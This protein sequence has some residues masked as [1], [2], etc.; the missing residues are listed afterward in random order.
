MACV[1]RT[2]LCRDDNIGALVHD[3]DTGATA[4]IDV[5]HAGP[6]LEALDAEGWSLSDILITHGHFD[7]VAGIPELVAKTGATVTAPALSAAAIGGV[8]RPVSEGDVIEVGALR[9]RVWETPGHCPD[10]VAYWFAAEH[11]VFVGDTLFALGCGR[12]LGSQPEQLYASI[13][14]ILGLPDETRIWC[15]HE[16]TLA[17]AR[18]AAAVDPD[19]PAL[20]TRINFI[21]RLRARG[22]LTIPTT[23]GLEKATN[24]FARTG[25]PSIRAGLDMTGA[26]AS[27]VFVALRARK[28]RFRS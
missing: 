26:S 7:H 2:F 28:D 11:A 27:E 13:E 17:N 10:H 3:A 14:R 12:V 20:K 5:P 1:I 16:Y 21:E 25:D 6:I 8:D 23:I 9:A 19:N 4:A 22:D 18:F 24:P 15:G